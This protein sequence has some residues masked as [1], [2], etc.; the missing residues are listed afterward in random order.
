M[1]EA[2]WALSPVV[3][4]Q[5]GFGPQGPEKLRRSHGGAPHSLLGDR[6]HWPIGGSK[7]Q[8]KKAKGVKG[9][10]F[11]HLFPSCSTGR[12]HASELSVE[13]ARERPSGAA[14][15]LFRK[16]P[17]G[18]A[19][20]LSPLPEKVGTETYLKHQD[21]LKRVLTEHLRFQKRVNDDRFHLMDKCRP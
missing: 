1:E 7:R 15:F 2:A 10:R 8:L 14:C 13:N 12:R 3:H 16:C 4:H 9:S 19:W 5:T 17:T 6:R 20:Q 18:G 21:R 11:I